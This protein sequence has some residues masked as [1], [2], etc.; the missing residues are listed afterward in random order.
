VDLLCRLRLLRLV[1]PDVRS[2]GT[3]ALDI[4]TVGT[5]HNPQVT[6]TIR[7]QNA[8]LSTAS[9]PFG[10][11]QV[12]ALLNVNNDR[13]QISNFTGQLGGG[14]VTAGGF[15][16]Y[17]PDVQFNLVLNGNSVRLRYPDGLRGAD[18]PLLAQVAAVADVYDA[19][20]TERPYKRAYSM[21]DA[22]QT[23]KQEVAKGWWDPHI[24][25]QFEKLV[26][27]GTG[28]FLSH[29]AAT[30]AGRYNGSAC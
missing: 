5:A 16:T 12:N 14:Q 26:R 13:V 6:G 24:F 28:N 19:L 1:S 27:S 2:S 22:L 15:I 4:R 7:M 21:T 20:T 17:R 25:E 11:E 23:M 8:A 3:M 9:I 10:L 18:V 30:A 29:R